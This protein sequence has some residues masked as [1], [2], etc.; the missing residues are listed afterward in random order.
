MTYV[1]CTVSYV[2]FAI[3]SVE[4]DSNNI[5]ISIQNNVCVRNVVGGTS[6][7]ELVSLGYGVLRAFH[8][9]GLIVVN[10]DEYAIVIQ[11]SRLLSIGL[12]AV[13]NSAIVKAG[14][15]CDINVS[16]IVQSNGIIVCTNNLYVVNVLAI[17]GIL[18]YVTC[19]CTSGV[20]GSVNINGLGFRIGTSP[21][22]VSGLLLAFYISLGRIAYQIAIQ[23]IV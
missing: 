7:N 21:D 11:I 16:C 12:I 1:A 13:S 5:A 2:Q 17:L 9:L 8:T 14:N 22:F 23:L 18:D 6:V 3:V 20:I 15:S 10:C 19:L 4:Y